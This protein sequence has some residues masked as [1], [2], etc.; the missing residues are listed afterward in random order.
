MAAPD[1]WEQYVRRWA[2]QLPPLR[3][4]PHSTAAIAKLLKGQASPTLLLGVTPELASIGGQTI[5]V[6]W[7]ESAIRDIW[8]GDTAGRRALLGDWRS[9]PLDDLSIGSVAGDGSL[10]AVRWPEDAN[11]VIGEI[12]RVLVDG[13]IVVLRAFVAP[14]QRETLRAITED[15]RS[16]REPSFGAAKWR[17]AMALTDAEGNVPVA[18]VHAVFQD[19]F[20]DRERLAQETGWSAA[21]IAEIDAY[22]GSA[23]RLAFP[24]RAMFERAAAPRFQTRWLA[25][26][27]YPLAARCPLLILGR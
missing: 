16:N 22:R 23:M 8:P 24:T 19:H 15:I 26:G 5:A 9:L 13:G 17:I 21:T 7:A 25:V 2:G 12:D 1:G 14:D 3:P 4:H 6:D 27:S 20:P 18:D 10:N 11:Q